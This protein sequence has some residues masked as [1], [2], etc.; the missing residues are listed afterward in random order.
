[1]GGWRSRSQTSIPFG[2]STTQLAEQMVPFEFELPSRDHDR[3]AV[4]RRS[5]LRS[6]EGVAT[7]M[8]FLLDD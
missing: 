6:I 7:P 4:T 5:D 2:T 8:G 3:V 1:M